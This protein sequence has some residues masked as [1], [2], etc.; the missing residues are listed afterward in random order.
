[1]MPAKAPKDFL[2][3]CS[4]FIT[5]APAVVSASML[6]TANFTVEYD[7]A[8]ARFARRLSE[9]AEKSLAQVASELNSHPSVKI[10]IVV[11]ST[12]DSFKRIMGGRVPEWGLAFA[13]MDEKKI[14]LKSPRLLKNDFDLGAVMT[15]EI[16]HI[17]LH[18]FVAGRRIPVWLHEGFAMYQS[19]EWKIGSSAL[20]GRAAITN[21][22]LD[23]SDLENTFPWSEEKADLAYAESFLVITFIIQRFGKEGLWDLLRELESG[24]D[25]DS[26]M[27]SAFGIG[28]ER[29][30][31]DWRAYTKSRF[32][33]LS[34]VVSPEVIWPPVVILFAIVY[35]KKQV[36]KRRR[37]MMLRYE[38]VEDGRCESSQGD[39]CDVEN[40]Q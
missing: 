23:L 27:R 40:D 15:H 19:K 16:A 8:D 1:M 38:S 28:Y 6:S 39:E 13:L 11:P 5:L 36:Q 18:E 26:A 14:V 10:R 2:F 7:S 4:F 37:M 9:Q 32:S 24:K 25:I 3:F 35:I 34:F 21:N 30:K 31:R 12:E 22:L 33:I 29:F 20:V 17:M